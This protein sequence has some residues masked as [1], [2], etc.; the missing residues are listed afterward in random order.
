[1]QRFSV[2]QLAVHLVT[3]LTAINNKNYSKTKQDGSVLLASGIDILLL[4]KE[5]LCELRNRDRHISNNTYL[6]ESPTKCTWVFYVFFVTLHLL[7][8]FRVQI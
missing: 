7:Y 1:M 8:I 5:W 6:I 2:L 4:G 3:N